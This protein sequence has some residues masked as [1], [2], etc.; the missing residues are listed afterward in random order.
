MEEKRNTAST[1]RKKQPK[2]ATQLPGAGHCI[3]GYAALLILI[4]GT[5]C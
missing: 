3:L 1:E 2:F 5:S 4:A